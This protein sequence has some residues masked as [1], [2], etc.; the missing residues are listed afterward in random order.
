MPVRRWTRSAHQQRPRL[1]RHC[2]C[3]RHHQDLA[4]CGSHFSRSSI[5]EAPAALNQHSTCRDSGFATRRQLDLAT[6]DRQGKR[7]RA[8]TGQ[9]LQWTCAYAFKYRC[10]ACRSISCRI[11]TAV[12]SGMIWSS[13]LCL[14]RRR[15][16]CDGSRFMSATITRLYATGA[17][18]LACPAA[19]SI[20]VRDIPARATCSPLCGQ[21]QEGRRASRRTI[22]CCCCGL[23]LGAVDYQCIYNNEI[24][25]RRCHR[26]CPVGALAFSADGS[27]LAASNQ[28]MVTL[29]DPVKC[30]IVVASACLCPLQLFSDADS[31]CAAVW[32]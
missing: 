6:A 4:V 21:W 17:A 20:P 16:P 1:L 14:L 3:R 28:N 10:W 18:T 7:A 15:C 22:P 12:L 30:V 23:Y 5:A 29:W 2:G 32:S 9:T 27:I 25:K 26:D 31:T 8:Y 11:V 24:T 19:S 13:A